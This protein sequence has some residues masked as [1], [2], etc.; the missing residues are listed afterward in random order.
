MQQSQVF[1]RQGPYFIYAGL[2]SAPTSW[3]ILT[4]DGQSQALVAKENELY[5]IDH[6]GQYQQQVPYTI[7]NLINTHALISL[8]CVLNGEFMLYEFGEFMLYEFGE[9]MLYEF[10]EFIL[11]EFGELMLYEFGEFMLYEFGEFMLYEFGEFMLYEFGE[12]M[13]YEFEEFMLYEF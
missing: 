1:S 12:F 13:L 3:D 8:L 4:M 11:Y 7:F 9:F 5:L 10:G 6:G 2:N